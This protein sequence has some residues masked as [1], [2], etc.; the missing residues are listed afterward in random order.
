MLKLMGRTSEE[1][2]RT[3]TS[4]IAAGDETH[5]QYLSECQ[6]KPASAFI[7][8]SEG[9]QVQA[10][11]WAEMLDRLETISPGSTKALGAA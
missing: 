3:L 7:R 9:Q 11:I 2:A 1:G 8:S 6:V 5:G 10:R 4:A